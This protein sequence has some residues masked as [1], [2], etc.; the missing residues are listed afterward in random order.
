MNNWWVYIIQCRNKSLYTGI[1]TDVDR[2]FDEH[3][4]NNSRASKYCA[5]LRPLKLVY[6]S[7]A[8]KNKSDASKEEYRIKQLSRK[9]KLNLIETNIDITKLKILLSYMDNKIEEYYK[10]REF[11]RFYDIFQAINLLRIIPYSHEEKL[12]LNLKEGLDKLNNGS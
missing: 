6:K 3:Q 1:T 9:D 10:N 12:I 2:R 8:Y 11:M 4:N 7:S 5:R